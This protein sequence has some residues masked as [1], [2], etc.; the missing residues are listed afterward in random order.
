MAKFEELA[1]MPTQGSDAREAPEAEPPQE[2]DWLPTIYG[3]A[4]ADFGAHIREAVCCANQG[5]R[6]K[7]IAGSDSMCPADEDDKNGLDSDEHG[8]YVELFFTAEVSNVVLSE[9]QRSMLDFDRVTTMRVYAAAA[10]NQASVVKEGDLLAKAD[11]QANPV[12]ASKALYTE[13]ETSLDNKCFKVQDISKASDIV[14]SRCGCTWKF[15]KKEK[16]EMERTA[17]LRP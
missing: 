3:E 9:Q 4:R 11:I 10:A 1:D 17:A 8:H 15:V 14:T 13:L 6:R 7:E 2:N 12:K 5:R 16:G